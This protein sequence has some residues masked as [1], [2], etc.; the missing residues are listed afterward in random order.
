MED[1]LKT[2]VSE[3]D[4]DALYTI[5][6]YLLSLQQQIKIDKEWS[7]FSKEIKEKSRFFPN[8]TAV[9]QRIDRYKDIATD[10]LRVG[11]CFFRARIYNPFDEKLIKLNEM[12]AQMLSSESP[13]E[14]FLSETMQFPASALF[15]SIKLLVDAEHGKFKNIYEDWRKEYQP[16]LGYNERASD[17]PP[18]DIVT[19][20]RANPRHISY[21]YAASDVN[22]A[23]SEIRPMNGQI[24]SVATIEIQKELKIYGF[25]KKRIW[26]DTHN[27]ADQIELSYIA[28]LFSMPCYGDETKYLPTQYICDYIRSLGYDGIR[29]DSSLCSGGHNIALFDTSVKNND[30]H[31]NY[32]I[33]DSKLYEANS[34]ITAERSTAT[35][36]NEI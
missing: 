28:E 36:H 15:V 22:T 7:A 21:L 14:D 11:D 6:L 25:D 35:P 31:E 32:K 16:F 23:I 20:G 5:V 27:F 18:S 30:I 3:T 19:E 34:N 26:D 33:I 29:Y 2:N 12:V 17:A 13:C 1:I 10:T 24:V 9:L 8:N 4:K